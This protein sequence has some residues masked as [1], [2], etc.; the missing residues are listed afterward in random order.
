MG[1]KIILSAIV[2]TLRYATS[3]RWRHVSM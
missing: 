3:L 1:Q 2:A